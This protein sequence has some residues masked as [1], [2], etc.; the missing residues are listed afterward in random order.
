MTDGTDIPMVVQG[1]SKREVKNPLSGKHGIISLTAQPSYD[2][3]T[4]TLAF[5]SRR[6]TQ[7]RDI[8]CL[9]NF[10]LKI[11]LCKIKF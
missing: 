2:S 1:F 11:N 6:A 4:L 7:L 5:D 10:G 9:E 3:P 8:E